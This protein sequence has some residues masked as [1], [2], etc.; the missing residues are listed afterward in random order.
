MQFMEAA[1]EAGT[2][3]EAVA[4]GQDLLR[5]RLA[6]EIASLVNKHGLLAKA[7]KACLKACE[8]R[9]EKWSGARSEDTSGKLQL[10]RIYQVR[11][12]AALLPF[13]HQA[14]L[15]QHCS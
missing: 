10:L 9:K 14:C 11:G 8:R 12:A 4:E 1:E 5:P 7:A 2:A 3:G 6:A 15:A 13:M